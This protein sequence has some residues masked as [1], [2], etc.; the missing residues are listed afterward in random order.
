MLLKDIDFTLDR[1]GH[2]S[3]AQDDPLF[4]HLQRVGKFV[5]AFLVSE[6]SKVSLNMFVPKG[7]LAGEV[8]TFLK[9]NGAREWKDSY[10]VSKRINNVDRLKV[11]SELVRTPT[12]V[13]NHLYVEN[14][15]LHFDFRFHHNYLD[16]ISEKLVNYTSSF[17]NTRILD[18][19]KSS[20]FTGILNKI[21]ESMPLTVIKW[22]T[23]LTENLRNRLKPFG[24][25]ILETENLQTDKHDFKVLVY[26]ETGTQTKA[27]EDVEE[28]SCEDLLFRIDVTHPVLL[29]V[30]DKLNEESIPRVAYFFRPLDDYAEVSAFVPSYLSEEYLRVVLG[31]ARAN[32][33][34]KISLVATRALNDTLVDEL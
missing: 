30:R 31:V 27:Q 17:E 16:E 22:R 20:G 1:S 34:Y 28:V 13:S 19:G 2:I 7:H 18:F 32:P 12:V 10:V 8:L 5:P 9:V 33:S 21:Q 15:T 23:P 11:I 3:L 4:G 6:G 24:S 26:G 25:C 29:A 14:G